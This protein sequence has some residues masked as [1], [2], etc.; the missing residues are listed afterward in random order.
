MELDFG[1]ALAVVLG[2]WLAL[3][4]AIK[5]LS[6]ALRAAWRNCLVWSANRAA[7]REYQRVLK[8]YEQ[9]YQRA[10]QEHR[11]KTQPL[12]EQHKDTLLRKRR[13]LV[14][15]DDY[16]QPVKSKW[17]NEK[18]YFLRQFVFPDHDGELP[19]IGDELAPY[20]DEL[21]DAYEAASP[22]I[23]QARPP[24]DPRNYEHFCADLLKSAGWTARVTPMSGDQGADIIATGLGTKVVLQCKLYTSPVGNKAVQEIVA[25]KAVH[26]AQYGCVV[27][28][29]SYTSSAKVLAGANA[30]L[31]LHHDEL[32]KLA[33]KLKGATHAVEG[34]T[35]PPLPPAG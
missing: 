2:V 34:Q 11:Q 20:I 24:A 22:V 18:K 1:S 12:V 13:Q 23:T 10:L 31:L 3:T 32:P 17:D 26:G 7:D 5:F 29:Q 30:I 27:S 4:I 14:I 16:G 6:F 21:L 15:T 9:G 33:E 19:P 35:P 25:A 8:D 28:N